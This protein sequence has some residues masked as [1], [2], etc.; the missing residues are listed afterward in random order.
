MQ[1][2]G[3]EGEQGM[4]RRQQ[5][6]DPFAMFD[7]MFDR[8]QRDFFGSS[9]FGGLMPWRGGGEVAGPIER[10]PRMQIR[11]ADN[12]LVITAELPG[13]DPSDVH[14]DVEQDLLTIRGESRKQEEREGAQMERSVS[15][16]RQLWLPEGV[17]PDQAQASYRNGV[18]TLQFTRQA[19]RP[20][21]KQIPISTE[22]S[23]QQQQQQQQGQQRAA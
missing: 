11:E 20:G 4:A 23:Q 10:V 12:K 17:D 7:A 3:A 18:L 16:F 9:L 2:A 15:Y 19:Q 13:L 8:M 21:A 5:Y 1:R 14:V 6:Q 22:S